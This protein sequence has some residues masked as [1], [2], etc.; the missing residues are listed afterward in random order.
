MINYYFKFWE[1]LDTVFLA[2]KKKPLRMSRIYAF[3]VRLSDVF[4]SI[5]ACFSSFGNCF[6]LLYS[7]ERQNKHSKLDV[8]HLMATFVDRTQSWAVIGLNLIVHVIMCNRLCHQWCIRP[9]ILDFNRLLL[10]CNSRGG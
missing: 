2:L 8:R 10:F 1:L 7:T 4:D 9:L 6:T 3:I 5:P